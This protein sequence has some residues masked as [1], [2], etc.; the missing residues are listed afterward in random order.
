MDKKVTVHIS[1]E[2]KE[3]ETMYKKK[4]KAMSKKIV[5]GTLAMATIL[6]GSAFNNVSFVNADNAL[7]IT[8]DGA[9][10]GKRVI[11]GSGRLSAIPVRKYVTLPTSS[12]VYHFSND[13]HSYE[14]ETATPITGG[15]AY[16]VAYSNGVLKIGNNDFDY[17]LAY[18]LDKPYGYKLTDADGDYVIVTKDNP[19]VPGK[20]DGSLKIKEIFGNSTQDVFDVNFHPVNSRISDSDLE[21]AKLLKNLGASDWYVKSYYSGSVID[22]FAE[23]VKANAGYK[24]MNDWKDET[25]GNTVTTVTKNDMRVVSDMQGNSYDIKFDGNGATNGSMNNESM[26]YGAAKALNANSYSRT[27][28]TFKGWSTSKTAT[29]AT[30]TDKQSVNNLTTTNG[31]TVTLYAVWAANSYNIK[32]DGNGATSGSMNNESMTY[33]TAKALST[34]AYTKNGYTFTGWN[35]KANGSGTAYANKA[36]VNN[37]ATSGTATLYAQ[38]SANSYSL[39][40]NANGGSCTE[41]SR[42]VKYDTQY[43]TLPNAARTGYTFDGWYTSATG[44]TKVSSTTVMKS[45]AKVVLYAHWTANVY[46]VSF[47]GTDIYEK[48]D[49][50]FYS[51]SACKNKI[52]K[53]TIPTKAGNRFKGY[54]NGVTK[55]VDEKGT[56]LSTAS[57]F[58]ADTVLS[59]KWEEVWNYDSVEKILT[60]YEKDNKTVNE[61]KTDA[62]VLKAEKIVIGKDVKT[63][64]NEIL[65]LFKD[66]KN[67]TA[68]TKNNTYATENGILYNAD[69]TT[70]VYCPTAHEDNPVISTKCRVIANGAFADTVKVNAVSLPYDVTEI[71]ANA[72]N[73]VTIKKV[74]VK[75]ENANIA[76]ETS[77]AKSA[78]IYG[79]KNSTAIA[80][81]TQND[82][83]NYVYTTIGDNFF[84]ESA[85]TEYVVPDNIVSIGNDA[86]RNCKSLKK[87]TLSD[88]TASI[89]EYAFAG[90]SALK[91]LD[92]SNVKE[93]HTGA[94]SECNTLT[95][96][97]IP[98]TVT[99]IVGYVFNNCENLDMVT[100]ESLDC[101]I[102]SNS[103]TIPGNVTVKCYYGSTAYDYAAANGN[104]I[105]L[106]AGYKDNTETLDEIS[107]GAKTLITEIH[108]GPKVKTIAE[109]ALKDAKNLTTVIFD[110]NAAVESIG[111]NAFAESGITAIVLPESVTEIGTGV[112]KD[113]KS[114]TNASLGNVKEV[115]EDTFAGCEV[116]TTVNNTDKWESIGKNALAKT[117][118]TEFVAG[119][120][121]KEIA[122]DAFKDS[123]LIMLSVENQNCK[124][125]DALIMPTTAMIKGYTNSTADIYSQAFYGKSCESFGKP[126]YILSFDM[127]GG[128]NGTQKVYAVN[129][130]EMPAVTVPERTDYA[131]AGYYT[132]TDASGTKYYN[133][134]GTSARTW[135]N[136][137]GITLYAA[138]VHDTYTV[139]F[140]G[141]GAAGSMDDVVCNTNTDVTLPKNTL[142]KDGYVFAGWSKDKDA[143]EAEYT[144]KD[145][146][147][148][149]AGKGETCTLYAVWKLTR[150]TVRFNANNG[151]GIS[152]DQTINPDVETKLDKNAFIRDGY[153]FIGW[154]EDSSAV[155]PTYK[156]EAGVKNLAK[157]GETYVLYAVWAKGNIPAY[158][159]TY[160]AN[161]GTMDAVSEN[162]F[163]GYE[164]KITDAVPVRDGF[165]FK[166]WVDIEN[167][168]DIMKA[169]DKYKVEK[170]TTLYAVWETVGDTKYTVN[171]HTQKA[172]GKYDTASYKM[173]ADKNT[174]V[175]L[176]PK[177]DFVVNKGWTVNGAKSILSKEIG[178]NTVFDVYL[179]RKN[180]GVTFDLNTDDKNATMDKAPSNAGIWGSTVTLNAPMPE[181]IGYVFRGWAVSKD[182]TTSVTKVTL[183][184]KGTTVYA[185]WEKTDEPLVSPSAKPSAG[186]DGDGN[187]NVEPTSEPVPAVI[188]TAAPTEEP[189]V[190]VP[191]PTPSNGNGEK[192]VETVTKTVGKLQYVVNTD[193]GT[194]TVTKAM[195]KKITK[196]VIAKTITVNGKKYKVTAISKNAFKGCKKLKKV[197]IKATTLKSIGKNAFKGI[198]KKA[199]FKV[200]RSK[201]KAYKK[202]LSKKAV[203]YRKTMK[204]SK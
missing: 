6:S 191:I 71:E 17:A 45:T 88:T 92:L 106:M 121:V 193:K 43:G 87:V 19:S 187:G 188:P 162:V 25:T 51:D 192:N 83:D 61:W 11:G 69:K 137:E 144:D 157:C 181:R 134:D 60:V 142:V 99:T 129:G 174:T 42:T 33:G 32:F 38:W 128:V 160:D 98:E 50:G 161:G 138:W 28:Y 186:P 62:S 155:I 81:A 163:K 196:A 153:T 189:T 93:I 201:Y 175:T 190:V 12:N 90:D 171:I 150:Y 149:L 113:C 76:D 126:A 146:I 86:F 89:G 75:N 203:G 8:F 94:F 156:D 119:D 164:T 204:I 198:N 24:F 82:R 104:K 49:N 53:I 40:F 159:V 124:F 64:D 168:L 122:E 56:I 35:T 21:S 29:S 5:V 22:S 55:A 136:A 2:T 103:T 7:P 133:A 13:K 165:V 143:S 27:G 105:I 34:N 195:S 58:T 110:K 70:L 10:S 194:A 74:I 183:G 125:P 15:T 23:Y 26:T 52:V 148:S 14:T 197:T 107:A 37:L 176:L 111:D 147:N 73:A 16:T 91:E 100:V 9:Y 116:L 46:K 202:L 152:V 96:V 178:E 108:V 177:A 139:K 4:W 135:D 141:N 44:G 101:V 59:A 199:K 179:D 85:M 120:S 97:T 166:G 48:Y 158:T 127:T 79:F 109:N 30:Y 131:F 1:P 65:S 145:V 68:D 66:C 95:H 151:S 63:M 200:T 115:K 102:N 180:V 39:A 114:L 112:L 36:S 67:I 18:G 20:F 172:D 78:K 170:A 167:S 184:E 117:A 41:G 31:G 54:Y 77:I 72:L 173:S 130:K 80:F 140:D 84:E 123:A 185:I 132:S 47:D 154:S 169:G 57:S 182:D 3:S 118:V